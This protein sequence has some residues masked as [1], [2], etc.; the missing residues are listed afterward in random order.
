VEGLPAYSIVITDLSGTPHTITDDVRALETCTELS[1]ASDSCLFSILNDG[2]VYSYIEKGCAVEVSTGME[3]IVTEKID[4][5]ITEVSKTLDG[6]QVKPI[7]RVSGEAGEIRLNNI[8]FSGKFYNLEI[9]ALVKAILGTTDYTTGETFRTLADIDASYAYIDSTPYTIDEATYV[10]KSL[11]AA[12]KELAASVGYE[13][14][15]DVNKKLHFFNPGAAVVAAT[16]TDSDLDGSPEITDEG[17]II[18]RAV[19]IG[20]FQQNTDETGNTQTTTV[21]VTSAAS[22]TQSF[23][24]TEDYLSSILVYTEIAGGGTCA[25]LVSIQKDSGGLPDGE[26]VANGFITLKAGS[27]VAAG[28]SEFRFDQNVTLTPGDT[29]HIVLNGDVTEGVYVGVDSSGVLDYK[30]RYPVRVAIM[31]N[32]ATSQ[33]DYANT[34]GS[35][36]IYMKV[37][38]DEKIEDSEYAERVANSLIRAEPKKVANITIHGDSITAGDIVR[39]TLSEPGIEIN[40]D[41][42]VITSTQTLGEIFIYNALALEEV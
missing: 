29:Y 39:L 14:Y 32:D 15:R 40:K 25:L 10:W 37:Y 21:L 2:D 38:R 24:P 5:F 26:T 30:T 11:G 6:S 42:K 19:V 1:D 36:G 31:V 35:P 41:M 17:D 12:I 16:I 8:F 4:G 3:G 13:W 7:M 27:V 20:G 18:N 33:S 23:V 22:K 34:D 9:S 28:Y